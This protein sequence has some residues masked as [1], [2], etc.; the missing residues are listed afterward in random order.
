MTSDATPARPFAGGSPGDRHPGSGA[1]VHLN[2]AE[3][4]DPRLR[5][6]H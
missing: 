6:I 4:E 5:L 3:T 1:A 2:D